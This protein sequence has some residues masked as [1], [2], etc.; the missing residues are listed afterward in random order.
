MLNELCYAVLLRLSG[1]LRGGF[2]SCSSL[3]RCRLLRRSRFF[4]RRCRLA[5][6]FVDQLAD[7]FADLRGRLAVGVDDDLAG[8]RRKLQPEERNVLV[9]AGVVP[10]FQGIFGAYEL[11]A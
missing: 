11:E 8:I 2:L 10:C 7:F 1:L 6:R 5:L 3:L 9:A 4:L